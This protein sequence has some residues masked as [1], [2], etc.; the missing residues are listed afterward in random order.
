MPPGTMSVGVAVADLEAEHLGVEADGRV[1]VAHVQHDMADL[2][3]LEPRRRVVHVRV[4]SAQ[5]PQ[6][7][8]TVKQSSVPSG[9]WDSFQL[10][11]PSWVPKTCPPRATQ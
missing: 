9:R 4:S 8:A 3:E 10:R 2:A 1:E 5:P 7:Q 6:A 11:P